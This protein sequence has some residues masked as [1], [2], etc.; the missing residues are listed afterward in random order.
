VIPAQW[1]K[2]D[3]KRLTGKSI[4]DQSRYIDLRLGRYCEKPSK[5]S[6]RTNVDDVRCDKLDVAGGKE[7][8]CDIL[9]NS[10]MDVPGIIHEHL[11]ARSVS[12][13]PP[14][15]YFANAKLE[16]GVVELLAQEICKD[17]KIAFSDYAYKDLVGRLRFFNK[18]TSLYEN[19]LEFAK[20]LFD[21]DLP[22][23]R[24]WLQQ[25]LAA[26]EDKKAKELQKVINYL[27]GG[28]KVG[29]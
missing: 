8:N 6:G 26:L 18:A 17:S 2:I 3:K 20:A 25:I 21:V 7:W 29:T 27:S 22:M 16:E 14:E 11:H 15:V 23:R 28:F 12:Y 9:V 10:S 13:W 19:D 24:D 4:E 5:W 1:G